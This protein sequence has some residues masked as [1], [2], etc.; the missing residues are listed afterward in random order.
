M[1]YTVAVPMAPAPTPAPTTVPQATVT[2]PAAPPQSTVTVTAPPIP[3]AP[4]IQQWNPVQPTPGNA[5]Q[6]FQVQPM[7]QPAA[8]GGEGGVSIGGILGFILSFGFAV[9]VVV[10][11]GVAI[12]VVGGPQRSNT[13]N[14]LKVLATIAL[15]A[16]IIALVSTGAWIL[17][18]N[19]VVASLTDGVGG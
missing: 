19:G 2:V 6:G 17:L 12:L 14:T 13:K 4:P 8:A 18:S 15:A 16:L 9:F 5:Q 3:Q 10:S 1:Q 11:V 7:Q